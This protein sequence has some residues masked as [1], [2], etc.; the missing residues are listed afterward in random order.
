MEFLD[1]VF[2]NQWVWLVGGVVVMAL[3]LLAPGVYLFWVGGGLLT[4]GVFV[5][6]YPDFALVAQIAIFIASMAAWILVGI[7]LQKRALKTTPPTVNAGLLSYIGRRV[8]AAQ[9]FSDVGNG[10][11][12]PQFLG[13]IKLEDTSY[14]ALSDHPIKAG[15]SVTIR[16][17]QAGRFIVDGAN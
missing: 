9:D 12:K 15:Q 6:L 16:A 17:Y 11:E 4:A 10:G 5:A 3:E 1:A 7:Y 2:G 8:L 13:R 14:N